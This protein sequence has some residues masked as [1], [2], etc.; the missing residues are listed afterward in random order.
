M[1]LLR[2]LRIIF[3]RLFNY[4]IYI[5]IFKFVFYHLYWFY[6]LTQLRCKYLLKT[7]NITKSIFKS[8]Y[9][10]SLDRDN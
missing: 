10:N 6:I 9:F 2:R 4:A 5:Y 8:L 1:N 7:S 3:R